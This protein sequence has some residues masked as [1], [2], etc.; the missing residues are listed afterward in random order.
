LTHQS[1]AILEENL[2]QQLEN[3]GY[4]SVRIKDGKD[5]VANLKTQL[6]AFNQTA[7][8]EKEFDGILNHLAKGNVFEKAKTLRDRFSFNRINATDGAEETVYVR[9]FDSENWTNNLFQVTHQITQEGRFKNR[10][11]VTLLVNGLPLVQI[12]LKRRG[13]EIKEAFNQINRY[14]K[15]SFWSN[16]GLFQY[17]QL[18]VISN[19]GNTKYLANN[20]LQSVK[21]TFFWADAQNKNIT[22]LEDFAAAFLNPDHLGKMIAQYIVI[23]E[24]HK[25]LMVLRPY[26]YHATEALVKRVKTSTDNAYIWHTTG[27]GKTLTSFKTSQILMDLPQ[28][29]KVVFVVDR[30]DLDYQTMKEFNAFKEGSVDSTDNTS[31]LVHQ[32]LGKYEDK[33]GV[34]KESKLIITTIQ[35]LNNAISGKYQRQLEDL[36]EERFVFIFDEC[37]R[38]QFGDTHERITKFFSKSQ[39]FGFTGTPIFADNA[40]KN[41]LGKRTTRDLFGDCLHKY[42]ITDAIRD[43]NVLRFGIEYYSVFKHKKEPKFDIQVEDIDRQEVFSDPIYQ[44]LVVDYIIANHDRKTFNKE[45]SALFAVSSI[46][47]AIAYYQIFRRKKIAGEHELRIA[48]I[49]TYG[50]NEEDEEATDQ[51]PENKFPMAADPQGE[52]VS[53]HSRDRLE[54][55]VEDYNQLYGTNY[56]T[57]DGRLFEAYFKDISKRLKEREKKNFNDEKDRLDIVIVVNMLLTGFDAK[58]VNTLYVDKNLKQHGLIQAYS[59]TNRILGEKKSQGNIL[60]FRNLKK[61]TDD[62]I[63]LFSNKDAIEVVVMPE[64][65]DIVKKFEEAHE[66]L[67][68][69]TPTY[70]SVN[71]LQSEDDE[72]AFVQAFRRLMRVLNVLQSLTEFDWADLPMTAQEY[73]DYKGKYLDLYQKVKRDRQK[74][75]VSILDDLDF[76]V[77]LLHR[78]RV[79]VAYIIKL[80]AQLKKDKTSTA[81]AKKKAIIDLIGGDVDLRS[82]RELIEKFIQENLPKIADA[83]RVEDEFE[84]FWQEQK[85]LALGKLCEEENLD[86]AQFKSLIDTYMYSGQEPIRDD[87]FKCLDNRP[88]ILQA[89][90]I[91]ERIIDKMKDYVEVFYRGMTA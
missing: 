17:V 9:F 43:E 85:V 53:K 50:A 66:T 42:V 29:Y 47:A 26:Q 76:E 20:A 54:S 2:I 84:L 75:K 36:R 63:S 90:H 59:R 55:F 91:G 12:E 1:E 52:F 70:Q 81:A 68:A 32:F 80:L 8:S 14:Q 22:E 60:C 30:K 45:Y 87:V 11:D 48:T 38:S 10:Y 35:K 28:V 72:A 40:Y 61:A 71:D 86:Q 82:K 18:F 23:N 4:A 62:A 25:I 69:L 15:H 64:Y 83:D 89:R 44:E 56:T 5:L 16:N 74:E 3:M 73:E 77:E 19:G 49:F 65:K 21:Q 27:S 41:E 39:L 13:L 57:K 58:K 7:Y 51:L 37:H 6:E 46:D 79:N 34:A 24:T 31:S 78:D 88:S 33:K 67:K